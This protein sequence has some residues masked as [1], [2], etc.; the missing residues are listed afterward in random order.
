MHKDKFLKILPSFMGKRVN[1][2]L[3]IW[4][5]TK[6]QSLF[7]KLGG[8]WTEIYSDGD[9]GVG[10]T[11][12]FNADAHRVYEMAKVDHRQDALLILRKNKKNF[13]VKD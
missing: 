7:L 1:G 4:K 5:G 2:G 6:M 8:S 3:C 9:L 11:N 10:I 12:L 13:E